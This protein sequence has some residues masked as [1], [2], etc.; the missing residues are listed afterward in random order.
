M[1][2]VYIRFISGNIESITV[3]DDLAENTLTKLFELI[4]KDVKILRL[5]NM[6]IPVDKIEFI[7]VY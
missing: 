1:K 3:K 2:E 6:V 5:G 7:K 4:H